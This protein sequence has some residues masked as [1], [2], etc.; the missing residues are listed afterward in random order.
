M[1][2]ESRR[3]Q[4][5]GKAFPTFD[6]P[7]STADRVE[8]M[9]QHPTSGHHA[10]DWRDGGSIRPDSPAVEYV[11]PPGPIDRV[12]DPVGDKD[13]WVEVGD[14]AFRVTRSQDGSLGKYC[15]QKTLHAVV[16]DAARSCKEHHTKYMCMRRPPRR[17]GR[18]QG[19]PRG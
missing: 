18:R 3:L 4:E 12:D 14:R 11:P 10:L 7:S 2:A 13:G 5:E 1:L 15:L 16:G 17:A 9:G 6:V 8:D 19:A